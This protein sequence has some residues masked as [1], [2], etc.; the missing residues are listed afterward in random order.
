MTKS[1][2]IL[3]I[4]PCWPHED[5]FGGQLRALHIGRALQRIGKVTLA[6]VSSDVAQPEAVKKTEA[7]F[8]VHS[9]VRIES[10]PNRGVVS[11]LRWAFDPRFLNVHGCTA[12]KADMQPLL[13]C[14]DEFDL[15]WML[16]SRIP[17]ILNRWNWGRSVLDV[18]DIPS[19]Y[20]RT[21]CRNG[22]TFQQK[23]KAGITMRLLQR[24]ERAWKERFTVLSVCSEADRSYLGGGRKI[25][26]IPNGFEKPANAVLRQV[27]N[28]P[29][30][31]FIGLYS[32]PP[33][34][35]GMKWFV[36][37]CWPLLKLKIP[38]L[39]LRVVGKDSDGSMKPLGEGVDALGFVPD[40]ASEIATWSA[41]I[42]PVLHGAGTR[43]KIADAFSR[44]CP[45]VS[46]KLG[47]FGYDVRSG[48]ELLIA[49]TAIDFANACALLLQDRASAIVMAERAFEAFTRK[50]TWDAIAP[51]IWTA[52]EDALQASVSH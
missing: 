14:L 28:P 10:L 24:R 25:H 21:V 8:G 31:G 29:R 23:L 16:N 33:N 51:R 1:T 3:Y 44:K 13:K 35:D 37:E 38:D 26:V 36:R 4:T 22:V 39:R 30:I 18:D 32:Y 34:L 45:V 27:A 41:M 9:T 7:E 20:Q 15:V 12:S 11:R 50:W 49:D 42:V 40:S 48:R 46:T 47:A 17:N 52:A 6:V 2:R 19:T 43:V 5:S